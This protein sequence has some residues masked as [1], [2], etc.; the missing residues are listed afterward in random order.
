MNLTESHIQ[1]LSLL[2]FCRAIAI[3][4]FNTIV[5]STI[6]DFICKTS[7]GAAS[8]FSGNICESK[9]S[10]FKSFSQSY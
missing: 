9:H 7:S 2:F 6:T 3:S 1:K 4:V 8:V 10:F 5:I